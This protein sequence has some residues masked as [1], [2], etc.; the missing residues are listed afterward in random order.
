MDDQEKTVK[1]SP[2]QHLGDLFD[3]LG[4]AMGQVFN[5]PGL[6][7]KARELGRAAKESA[8]TL[9]ERFKDDEVRAKFRDVGKAAQAFGRSVADSFGESQGK[10]GEGEKKT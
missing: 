5:D 7:E 2:G 3:M 9:G 6:R 8:E 4:D 10:P 1:K